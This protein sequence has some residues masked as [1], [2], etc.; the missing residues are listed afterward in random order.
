MCNL[1]AELNLNGADMMILL[2][3]TAAFQV[4]APSHIVSLRCEL[5]NSSGPITFSLNEDAGKATVQTA[6]ATSER[7][8]IFVPD[9]VT[10]V[11]S[12]TPNYSII[13]EI[14]RVSLAI[15]RTTTVAGQSKSDQG[16]CALYE[17]PKRAF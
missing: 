1:L 15:T 2:Y 4:A 6:A 13:F 16:K 3:A 14:D 12:E 5:S 8:A 17:P 11:M 9:K 7:A 10:V